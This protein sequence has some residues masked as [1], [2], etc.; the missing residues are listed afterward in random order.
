MEESSIIS[1]ITTSISNF[2]F[3][4]VITGFLLLRFEKKIESLN[5]TI[6]DL[7]QVIRSEVGKK[8]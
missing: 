5:N 3:P 7:I 6:M 8:K 2:G 1:L 4:I